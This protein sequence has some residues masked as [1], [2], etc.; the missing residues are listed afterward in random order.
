MLE[1][2]EVV[3]RAQAAR[4]P[5]GERPRLVADEEVADIH[6]VRIA[7]C[8]RRDIEERL[9]HGEEA[10]GA[11][12]ARGGVRDAPSPS[13]GRAVTLLEVECGGVEGARLELLA[14]FLDRR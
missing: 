5:V 11:M 12:V 8:R 13:G 3:E 1:V 7:R 6:A 9:H 2:R 4:V 14:G 10:E